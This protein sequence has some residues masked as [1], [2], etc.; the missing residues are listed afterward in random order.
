MDTLLI[1]AEIALV[2]SSFS[3]QF[4]KPTRENIKILLIGAILCRG[5]RRITAILR[6][7]GLA[8]QSGFS[9]YHRVLSTAKFNSIK[10]SGILLSMLIALLP[11]DCPIMIVVDET[12]ERRKGKKIKAKGYYR[13]ALRS[14]ESTLVSCLGLKW[15]CMMLIVP[16]PFCQRPWALPFMTILAPSKR[17][18]EAAGVPHRTSIQW[19]IVMLKLVC[20]WLGNKRRWILIGD[21]AYACFSLAQ[22]CV[23]NKVTQISRLRLDAQ[24][25]EYPEASRPGKRGRKSIKGQRIRL[26]HRLN[27]EK[28]AWQWAQVNW[29]CEKP[30]TV[31]FIS[32]TCLWYRAGKDAI[33]LRYVLVVD[34]EGKRRTEV[35]YSTDVDLAPEKIIEYYVR[36]WNIEVTF[37]ESR[38]HLG[39][40]TQRQWSDR[41]IARTT[42]LLMGLYSLITL[43]AVELQ[44]TRRLTPSST[45][46]YNKKDN[47]T[48]SDVIAFV[49]RSIWSE[50]YLSKSSKSAD[51]MEIRGTDLHTLINQ[52]AAA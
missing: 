41:S 10:I 17:A 18:D 31:K 8:R 32:E 15:Q 29:Y 43:F 21:G 6:V 1:P 26:S 50:R 9:K 42:P 22:A 45:A 28:Q 44:K 16:L 51:I 2:I 24:L 5:P 48:F 49:K 37:E 30:K 34:P 47:A 11:E 35:F 33:N 13:D 36:R 4:T 25:Y 23:D 14:S 7:M 38:A 20:R 3:T 39:F 52:L 46:W 40:Q 12:L 27:D 19:T